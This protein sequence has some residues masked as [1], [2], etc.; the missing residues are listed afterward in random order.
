MPRRSSYAAIVAGAASNTSS[1]HQQPTTSGA[2]AHLWGFEAGDHHSSSRHSRAGNMSSHGNGGDHNGTPNPWEPNGQLPYYSRAYADPWN[3]FGHDGYG[4][5]HPDHFF[6]PSYLKGSR[7]AQ[8]L[9]A[10]HR[11]KIVSG[12]GNSAM[13]PSQPVSL[14]T[15]SSSVNLPVKAPASHRGVTF[16]L[17]EK[18][19]PLENEGLP[20]LPSKWNANDKHTGL[21]VLSDGYEVKYS[22]SKPTNEREHEA[23]SIRADH[24]MPHQGGVYYFEVTIMTRKREDSS[25]SIGFS[26]RETPLSRPPGWEPNSWAYHGD[27]GH[28][29]CCQSSGKTYGPTFG[30]TDDV[31]GCGVNFSNGSAFFTKNGNHL[32]IAFRE[33]KGKLFPSIGLRRPGEHI[34]VNF[35]QTPFIYDIDGMVVTEKKRLQEKILKTS[36]GKLAPP[37]DETALIQSLV[38]QYLSHDGYVDTARAFSQEVRSEKQALSLNSTSEV[39]GFDFAEN[40]DAYHRQ[41]IRNS[42]LGGDVDQALKLTRAHY[43][44]VLQ[45]NEHI[46]FHLQCRKFIEMIRLAAEIRSASLTQNGKGKGNDQD[47]GWYDD[48][49]THDMEIDSQT[50][51]I[52]SN[53]F[54]KMDT[55]DPN[56]QSNSK[57]KNTQGDYNR[58]LEETINFGKQ[59]QVE[60]AS[61]PRREVQGALQEAFALLAYEDPMKAPD[62]AWMLWPDKRVAVAEELNSAILVSLGKSS[63]AALEKLIQQTTVLV[64]SIS[65]EN[66]GGPTSFVNIDDYMTPEH[67]RRRY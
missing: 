18:A 42:I 41:Q 57:S 38:L 28:S 35:G 62:V 36:T 34:R 15:S 16:D 13:Q 59:L 55:D 61:D 43:P 65:A 30:A 26:S 3:T 49:V 5:G 29:F 52:D 63:S 67:T 21:E 50:E 39:Q 25:I 4:A 6:V 27:D 20:P 58:L 1:T 22:G 54:E 2:F 33:V 44:T 66:I 24:P 47:G 56:V 11:A 40:E 37:L 9:E 48:V 17:I 14:S 32:G 51:Y 23:F 7:Y 12:K 46:Y 19:P 64:E 60:F 8:K 31:I 45:D 10:S 53:G